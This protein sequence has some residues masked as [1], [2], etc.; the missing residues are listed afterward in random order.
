VTSRSYVVAVTYVK[1]SNRGASVGASDQGKTSEEAKGIADHVISPG[2]C[3]FRMP[4][5]S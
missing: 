4:V 3:K 5:A 1:I 2:M